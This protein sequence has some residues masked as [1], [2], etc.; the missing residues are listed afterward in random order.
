MK[1]KKYF[2]SKNIPQH[3]KDN[4]IL[5]C[6]SSEIFWA[7]GFGISEKI[8]VVNNCTHVIELCNKD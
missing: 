5:L 1:L 6:K 7:S 2:I 4:I 8:K 3:K